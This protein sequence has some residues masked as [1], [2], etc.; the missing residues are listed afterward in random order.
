MN[1]VDT[2]KSTA[3]PGR[4]D[5]VDWLRGAAVVLM[6]Q[7][8]LYDAWVAPEIKLTPAYQW[9]RFLGGIPSRLFL[10]LVGVSM[11]LRFENQL[12]KAVSDRREMVRGVQKRGLQILALAYLFRIQEYVL[13]HMSQMIVDFP[14]YWRDILRIDILNCI[15]ASMVLV[16]LVA[17][18]R[19]GRPA[20][21][22]AIA[23]MLV[24]VVLGPIIG[25]AHFPTWIPSWLSSY[26]GGQR[27]MA[28]FSIF[29]WTGWVFAGVALG[30]FWVRAS[31]DN[32]TQAWA[33]AATGAGGAALI[34]IVNTIRK[35][36]PHVIRYP[37]DLVQ[38]MGP[39]SFF[40]RLGMNCIL[41]FIAWIVVRFAGTRFSLMCQFGRTSLLIYWIHVDLCY[42]LIAHRLRLY[43]Q[44]SMLQATMGLLVMVGL[45]LGVS[46]IKTRWDSRRRAARRP[47]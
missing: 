6:I 35:I 12:R 39:G 32:R 31:R 3:A 14:A 42:G 18:P 30:H 38:Q 47:A 45:M 13:G 4:M 21:L 37:S 23:G 25:P 46:V 36:D 34:L 5:V 10:M 8:H 16:P 41:A 26:V 19:H 1:R 2:P 27:P 40:Y 24:C 22:P 15:G 17:A 20:W 33:F 28:W 29:P 44:L 9:T 43:G 11:A 7:T